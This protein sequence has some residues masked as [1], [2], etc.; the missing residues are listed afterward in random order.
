MMNGVPT[1]AEAKRRADL[2]D[3]HERLEILASIRADLQKAYQEV[4]TKRHGSTPSSNTGNSSFYI[5]PS[6]TSTSTFIRL[7][8]IQSESLL[9]LKL[10]ESESQIRELCES[11]QTR[12]DDCMQK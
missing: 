10:D 9:K 11:V 5:T 3:D 6:T 12:I 7:N 4:A 2:Q 8:A 1:L